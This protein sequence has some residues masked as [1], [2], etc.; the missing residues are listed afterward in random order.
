MSEKAMN[1]TSSVPR[2]GKV[3]GGG[4]LPLLV[5]WFLFD[6]ICR[7]IIWG[8]ATLFGKN[9]PVWSTAVRHTAYA[10]LIPLGAILIALLIWVSYVYVSEFVGG[11]FRKHQKNKRVENQR[12]DG[13]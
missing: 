10:I 4:C 3:Y 12:K 6:L 1:E 2:A 13:Q 8:I 7:A 9:V 11:F 5:A